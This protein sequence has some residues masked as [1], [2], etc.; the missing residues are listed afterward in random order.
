M[1]L[2][3][4]ALEAAAQAIA[5]KRWNRKDQDGLVY[6]EQLARTAVRTYLE[7]PAANLVERKAV[8]P[9][10]SSEDITEW[11]RPRDVVIAET[12]MRVAQIERDGANSQVATLRKALEEIAQLQRDKCETASAE[13]LFILL[14]NKV[15]IACA[16]L[17]DTAESA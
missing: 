3:P 12:A 4:R 7:H 15:Y 6:S 2:E 13:M 5:E 8:V 10:I 14:D 17:A 11:R 9:E 16:A 1:E